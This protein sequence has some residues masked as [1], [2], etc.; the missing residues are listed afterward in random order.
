MNNLKFAIITVQDR[1]QVRVPPPQFLKH[2]S[3]YF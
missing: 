1:E 2:L 3:L